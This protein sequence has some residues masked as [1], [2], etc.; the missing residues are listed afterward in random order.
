[1]YLFPT[2]KHSSDHQF[3]QTYFVQYIEKFSNQNLI[4]ELGFICQKQNI[5]HRE[6]LVTL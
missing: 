4:D 6:D 2:V 1:M 5:D 3:S